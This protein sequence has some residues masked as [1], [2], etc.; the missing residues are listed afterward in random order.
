M[1]I[2]TLIFYLMALIALL[3]SAYNYNK[4][5][6]LDKRIIEENVKAAFA[7]EVLLDLD[8]KLSQGEIDDKIKE[9]MDKGEDVDLSSD[10]LYEFVKGIISK[11]KKVID[12]MNGKE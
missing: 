12:G 4:I 9:I 2:I 3:L 8:S 10:E 1:T 5:R 11:R 7:K 6:N